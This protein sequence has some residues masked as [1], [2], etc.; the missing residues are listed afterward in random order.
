MIWHGFFD[1]GIDVLLHSALLLL[2]SPSPISEE[3]ADVAYILAIVQGCTSQAAAF[4]H[5]PSNSVAWTFRVLEVNYFEKMEL[6]TG[7]V[8][9]ASGSPRGLPGALPLALP[10]A[11]PLA[12]SWAFRWASPGHPRGILGGLSRASPESPRI[13]AR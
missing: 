11:L 2:C 12:L 5:L 13:I 10:W 6:A 8:P 3:K 9:G 7:G 1:L 4:R